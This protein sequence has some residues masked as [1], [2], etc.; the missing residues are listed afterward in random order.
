MPLGLRRHFLLARNSLS[1]ALPRAGI[2]S[3]PLATH[4]QSF[5]MPESPVTADIHQPF[6]V[7]LH[8]GPQ[9]AFN[10]VVGRDD[11]TDFRDLIVRQIP[12]LLVE[13]D[14][15]FGQNIPRRRVADPVNVGKANLG[16][17]FLGQIDA[18][19][20]SHP[21]SSLSLTLFV[22]RILTDH[23]DNSLSP[24]DLAVD[25]HFP[26]RGTYFHDFSVYL[27]L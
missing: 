12:N 10:F 8:F 18:C 13:I 9:S 3:G 5:P 25:A 16:T 15:G 20:T 22:F 19:D 23:A 7:H 6:D 27:Y 11:P 1:T 4:R 21:D 26:D 2:S 14:A 17:L 24:Y